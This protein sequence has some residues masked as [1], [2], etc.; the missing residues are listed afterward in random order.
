MGSFLNGLLGQINRFPS[1]VINTS[2]SIQHPRRVP[3][4]THKSINGL[5][6]VTSYE[7]WPRLKDNLKVKG[8]SALAQSSNLS[9]TKCFMVEPVLKSHRWSIKNLSVTRKNEKKYSTVLGSSNMLGLFWTNSPCQNWTIK[10]L[11]TW[12]LRSQPCGIQ[13]LLR[14]DA[15][16]NLGGSPTNQMR[17]E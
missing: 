5:K 6:P 3:E 15:A 10:L 11:S 12:I 4:R 17:S 14:P 13:N 9:A 16:T 2:L 8:R 1:Q 7:L